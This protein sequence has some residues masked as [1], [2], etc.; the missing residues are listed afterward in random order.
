MN[1]HIITILSDLGTRDTSLA[2]MKAALMNYTKGAPI[3]DISHNIVANDLQQAA[4]IMSTACR[5][6]PAGSIHVLCVSVFAGD[7]PCILLAERD[8]HYFI[9]PDN[10]ILPLTFG[11]ETGNTQLCFACKK[12]DQFR[13][14]VNN[15][16]QVIESVMNGNTA[17]FP[18]YTILIVPRLL[19]P[20]VLPDAIDC[21][22]LHIDR[23]ENVVLNIK[24][25]QF[26]DAVMNRLF[27]IKVM[28][29]K[30][31]TTISNNYNEVPEGAPLARFNDA[32]YLEIAS[33]HGSA[34]ALLGLKEDAS[35]YKTIKIF[36]APR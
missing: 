2:V 1:D 19:Q 28:R 10:G 31:I 29:H 36:L 23:Y 18:V 34:K 30:D 12:P 5:Y 11:I 17:Q 16:G 13:E 4:Y 14:W 15:A 9:A 35:V 22:I 7:A 26:E 32:G 21:N 8:G 33:N 3:V 6:F 20:I 24:R 27:R 25:K